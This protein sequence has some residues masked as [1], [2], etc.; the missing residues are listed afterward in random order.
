MANVHLWGL[1]EKRKPRWGVAGLAAQV[2]LA[3]LLFI[4]F[5]PYISGVPAP[6]EWMEALQWFPNWLWF[7][8]G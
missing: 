7:S 2:A 8:R 6:V 1:L 3:V 4:A 5:F